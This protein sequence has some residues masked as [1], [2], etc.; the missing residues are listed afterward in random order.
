LRIGTSCGVAKADV[1]ALTAVTNAAPFRPLPADASDDK[2][3]EFCFDYNILTVDGS[4]T[5][6]RFS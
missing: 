2:T 1:A 6:W 5:Y 3:I 4:G